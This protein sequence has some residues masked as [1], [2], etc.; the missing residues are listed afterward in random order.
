MIFPK[1]LFITLIAA[2]GLSFLIN[3]CST[4]VDLIAPYKSTPVIIGILDYTVDTQFVRINRT[5]LGE[6]D[7]NIYAQIKD[8]VE[9]NV[10]EVEAWIYKKQNGLVKDSMELKHIVKPSRDPGVFYNQDV[11]YYYTTEQLFTTEEIAFIRSAAVSS[12]PTL[13]TYELKVVARGKTYTAET[14]FPDLVVGSIIYPQLTP[15]FSPP[16]KIEMYTASSGTYRNIN[17]QYKIT[18]GTARYLGVYRINFDY[19]TTDGTTI[20]NQFIDYNLGAQD[21]SEG[22]SS[23]NNAMFP[24]NAASWY[25]FLGEKFKAIPNIAKVRIHDTEFRLT[26]ANSI[27]NTYLKVANPVSEFTPV[28]NT[29]TN[30][31]NDAIGILGAR[32]SIIRKAY[33]EDPSLEALNN[34]E[35]TSAPGLSYCV[36][37]WTGSG[38]VCNP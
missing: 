24:F 15:V 5:Y 21:N 26:G 2:I 33:L 3:S 18:S 14:D 6:G 31:D 7:A 8:S 30:F 38:Y 10:A 29:V 9:Y 25:S 32:T 12:N 34:G 1:S 23:S 17:F 13:M 16:I 4:D 37:N 11:G 27:L 35:F 36:V 22:L 20:E 28:L 19:V